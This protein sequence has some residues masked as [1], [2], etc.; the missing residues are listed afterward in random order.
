MIGGWESKH[1]EGGDDKMSYSRVA[2]LHME[3][4]GFPV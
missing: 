1:N 2:T 3:E 4:I